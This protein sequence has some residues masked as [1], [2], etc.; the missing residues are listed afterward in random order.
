MSD[1]PVPERVPEREPDPALVNRHE[2]DAPGHCPDWAVPVGRKTRFGSPFVLKEDGGDWERDESV[3]LYKQMF[4]DRTERQPS[5]IEAVEEWMRGET[6]ACWCTPEQCHAEVFL[7]FLYGTL[8]DVDSEPRTAERADIPVFDPA[9]G[10]TDAEKTNPDERPTPIPVNPDGIHRT[11]VSYPHWVCWRFEWRDGEWSKPPINPATGQHGKSNEPADAVSFNEALEYHQRDDTDTDGLG[12]VVTDSPFTGV[13]L[14]DVYDPTDGEFSAVA[15]DIFD[16]L[17][18]PAEFSPS[19]RGGRCFVIGDLPDG[20]RKNDLVELYDSGRY[21]TVTGQRIDGSPDD[22]PDRE[23]GEQALADVHREYFPDD[24]ADNADSDGETEG[25]ARVPTPSS[26]V[27]SADLPDDE[28]LEK[29]RTAEN[30]PTFERLWAGSTASYPSHSEADSA[31]AMLLAFW[32]GGDHRQMDRLF[33]ESGLMREK[34]DRNAGDRTYGELTIANADDEA[35]GYYDPTH[36]GASEPPNVDDPDFIPIENETEDDENGAISWRYVC[37]QYAEEGTKMGRYYATAALEDWTKWMHVIEEETLWV[38]D[39]ETGTFNDWGEEHAAT[40]LERGL[41]PFYSRAEKGE[42]IDRL[43]AR[44]QTHREELDGGAHPEPLL[45]VGNCVVDLETG[46]KR[47]HDP[48]YK[49]TRGLAWEFSHEHADTEPILDFL[50]DI[51]TRTEDRD[52]LIDH[53]AH[54]LMPGHP[55]RAFVMMYGPGAN[56]KTQLGQLFR[57]FVGEQN[58]ASVELPD[59]TGG[60]DFATGALPGKFVN[61]GDDVSVSEIRDTSVLKSLTGSGTQRANAKNEKQFDFENEAAMF[62]SANE[63]PRIA[64]E[65]EAI[66]DRLYPI[67]MPYQ[68]KGTDEYD[69]DNPQHK[70]KVP[71]ISHDLLAN[72]AAMRG[73]LVLCVEHAKRLIESNGQYSMPEGPAERRLRYEAASDPISRFALQ[74][75]E[76]GDPSDVVLKEDAYAV[77]KALCEADDERVAAEDG[78]KR[79]IAQQSGIDVESTRTRKLTPGASRDR[80]WRHIQFD[81]AATDYMSDRLRKRY[82]PDDEHAD[83]ADTSE[84]DESGTDSDVFDA[85]PVAKAV[86]ALTGYITVTVEVVTTHRLGEAGNG[87]KAI[88]KD[89][90]GAIDVVAWNDPFC[91]HLEDATGAHVVI[92]N[93]EVTEYEGARQL[94]PIAGLT[95]LSY[96]QAGVGHTDGTVTDDEQTGLET[97][98]AEADGGGRPVEG[99]QGKI[100][101][102]LRTHP[103]DVVTATAI[104]EKLYEPL[105]DIESALAHLATKGRIV[106]HPDGYSLD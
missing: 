103:K 5:Y 33:R 73:L 65:K 53:L 97:A 100:I 77:Y 37:E 12:F 36:R 29:A 42:V 82:F 6:L 98:Q 24:Y 52:T 88:A 48:S 38:Y 70:Q 45:C 44:N 61:V 47:S 8:G 50:D 76:T 60:D 7:A 30:G 81:D 40:I 63:P 3:E 74:C 26:P 9:E 99:M 19:G 83:P 35:S 22:I 27:A 87:V 1:D 67:T 86:E 96:I 59:L 78:F 58:A 20:G 34:W 55:Y 46:T 11:L 72:D 80:G 15:T 41:G 106:E 28:L 51:T 21:L 13:D 32:T 64:E 90:S 54:G 23:Y 105:D 84:D 17:E 94:S 89:A 85:V 49:F 102:H 91:T 71:G 93:V 31:L 62:F 56:G 66:A 10:Y 104:A 2:Y 68:F 43:K 95:K 14:D 16:T 79:Q 75:F 25:D 101:E 57:G 4:L 39:G 92:E 18:S 69:P